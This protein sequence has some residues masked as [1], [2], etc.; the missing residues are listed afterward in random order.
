MTHDINIPA[1][2]AYAVDSTTNQWPDPD[3]VFLDRRE[4]LTSSENLSCLRMLK[5]QKSAD[6]GGLTDWGFAERGNAVE[7]WAVDK[8]RASL[9]PDETL[10]Y[11]GE[12]QR[13]FHVGQL[14]GTPDGIMM[15]RD[16]NG[17]N[18]VIYLLEVKS[19]DPRKNLEA[20][21]GPT[22]QHHS[23]VM[24]NIW[25]ARQWGHE[26]DKGVIIYI[27]ASNFQRTKQFIV[28]FDPIVVGQAIA[29]AKRLFAADATPESLPAEGLTNSGCTYCK[30]TAQCDAIQRAAGSAT[31]ADKARPKGLPA[32]V[33]RTISTTLTN[34]AETKARIK[35]LEVKADALATELKQHLA[36]TEDREITNGAYIARLRDRA[37]PKTLDVA[38]YAEATGTPPDAFYKIGKPSMTLTVEAVEVATEKT[39]KGS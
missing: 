21:S 1:F 24:Q 22:P 19:V 2:F 20:M 9:N 39:K 5:F 3:G 29:R 6:R 36:D 37:G 27:D 15:V 25:L 17:Q 11:A 13:S 14:S 32:F 34:Y 8:I 7:A 26:I 12:D 33:P 10:A 18:P 4:F 23:Q 30:F 16:D 31:T 35:E 28:D 38:A